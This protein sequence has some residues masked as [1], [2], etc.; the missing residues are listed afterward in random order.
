M[1]LWTLSLLAV[2]LSLQGAVDPALLNLVMPDAKVIAGVRV[3]QAQ[4]SPFGQFLLSQFSIATQ[5]DKLV[6]T[7]GFD[8]LRDLDEVVV[9]S[10]GG[11]SGV[12]IGKGVFQPGRVTSALGL[13]G[14]QPVTYKGLQLLSGNGTAAGA[15]TFLDASTIAVGQT[16]DLKALIDRKTSGGL[17]TGTLANSVRDA[18]GNFDAWFVADS[19][20]SL[21][22]A[23][24]PQNQDLPVRV[25]QSIKQISGGV[26]FGGSTINVT[27]D[28]QTSSTQDAQ[29]LVDVFRFLLAMVD[30]DPKAAAIAHNIQFAA[31]GST[32]RVSF[33]M[34]EKDAETLFLQRPTPKPMRRGIR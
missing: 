18:S 4:A 22:G 1:K 29:A 17:Y 10:T 32:A 6:Q 11:N 30:N 31:N 12:V 19:P 28:A 2:G 20:T 14:G 34:P 26:R 5:R 7:T 27:A 3:S 8:P 15:I 13:L 24:M 23:G 21:V 16:A 33:E 25:M 9:A